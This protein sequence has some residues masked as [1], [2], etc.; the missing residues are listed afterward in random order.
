M[1]EVVQMFISQV[2]GEAMQ[3][4]FSFS[5]SAP[6]AYSAMLGLEHYL[7]QCG[8]EKGLLGLIKV[9]VSQMN[10]CAFCLDMHWKSLRLLG[11]S[12]TRLFSLDAW[13][14][15]PFYSDR[16]RAALA[17]AEALT[18]ITEGHAPDAVYEEVR[19]HFDQKELA[20]LTLAVA[21]INA[22]NRVLISSRAIPGA[23]VPVKESGPEPEQAAG[24]QALL[25][26][27]GADSK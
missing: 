21:A 19:H 12:E 7:H 23:Y 17:W 11:E 8:L 1:N 13:R 9:R 10:G 20:D 14:E 22:W 18:R 6:G 15:C 2:L 3:P 16:E 24:D 27:A 4:R 25:S 5:Q 26:R